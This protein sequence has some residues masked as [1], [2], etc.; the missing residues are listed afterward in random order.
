MGRTLL[1]VAALPFVLVA[2]AGAQTVRV[3]VTD[4][5]T[6]APVVGA[7]VTALGERWQWRADSAGLAVLKLGHPGSTVFTVRRLGFEPAVATLDVPN[8]D[9][10]KVHVILH[11]TG[12]AVLE[13][14]TIDASALTDA[15]HMTQF[16]YHR[17]HD[18]GGYFIT[19]RDIERSS[20]FET[21]DLLRSVPGLHTQGIRGDQ[22]ASTRG[23]TTLN[24]AS[25]RCTLAVGVD[26]HVYPGASVDDVAPSE[27]YGIEVYNGPATFPAQYHARTI[28]SCGLVMIW[29]RAQRNERP[30]PPQ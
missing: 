26:G 18:A 12:A 13:A 4:Y 28:S 1:H 2:A 7:L 21:H 29:T 22:I 3:R 15:A 16:D 10:L 19:R 11:A 24:T 20:P 23:R 9:T 14:V 6:D 27:I 30:A 8:R 25:A 5:E 17:T